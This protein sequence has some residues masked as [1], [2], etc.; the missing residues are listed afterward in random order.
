MSPKLNSDVGYRCLLCSLLI[1]RIYLAFYTESGDDEH[2]CAIAKSYIL[3]RGSQSIPESSATSI[4]YP[5]VSCGLPYELISIFN[6]I[7]PI[8]IPDS[9]ALLYI[10]PTVYSLL[11]SLLIEWCFFRICKLL[12]IPN[13]R[14]VT[15]LYTSSTIT[16]SLSSRSLTTYPL[17]SN[18][19]IVLILFILESRRFCIG[20]SIRLIIRNII[21]GALLTVGCWINII[22]ILY[23]VPYIL[24]LL[25]DNAIIWKTQNQNT[26]IVRTTF[27]LSIW[28]TFLGRMSTNQ[29]PKIHDEIDDVQLWEEYDKNLATEWAIDARGLS[30]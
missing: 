8:P 22:F 16:L 23:S 17:L 9:D 4:I 3:G 5:L 20:H 26:K 2:I 30:T 27:N 25:V 18:L 28:S 13:L 21:C 10:F 15:L 12:T 6:W 14:S 29:Y 19:L 24:Y 7:S 1:Y 11:I